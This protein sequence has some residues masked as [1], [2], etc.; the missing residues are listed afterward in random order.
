MRQKTFTYLFNIFVILEQKA[1]FDGEKAKDC[2][3]DANF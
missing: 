2:S 1:S 3:K